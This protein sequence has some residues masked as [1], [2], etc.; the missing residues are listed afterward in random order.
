MLPGLVLVRTAMI[1]SL[2]IANLSGYI[3]FSKY[4]AKLSQE[5]CAL[6]PAPSWPRLPLSLLFGL[7]HER[8]LRLQLTCGRM[9]EWEQTVYNITNSEW[10]AAKHKVQIASDTCAL[11]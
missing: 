10:D 8:T 11:R 3:L 1:H 9:T 5:A 2:I 7:P 6:P 4:Y